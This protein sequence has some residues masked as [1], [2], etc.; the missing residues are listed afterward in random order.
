MRARRVDKNQNEIIKGLMKIGCTVADTSRAGEGFPDL[1]CGYRGKNFM[2][3]CKDGNKPPSARKLTP[4]QI[5]FHEKWKGQIATVTNLN[6]AIAVVT[7]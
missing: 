5:R 3:E 6:E 1:V 2:I 4:A 7:G